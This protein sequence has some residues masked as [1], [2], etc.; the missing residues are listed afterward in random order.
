[1]HSSQTVAN[2]AH[3]AEAYPEPWG[4]PSMHSSTYQHSA[5]EALTI[6]CKD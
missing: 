4:L 2:M 5:A 1:M 3:A 6:R